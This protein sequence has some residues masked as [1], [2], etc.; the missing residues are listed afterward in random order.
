[1]KTRRRNDTY[2][3]KRQMEENGKKKY[4]D[5]KI[6]GPSKDEEQDDAME[7]GDISILN[8]LVGHGSPRSL[9]L[10]GTLRSG[11]V[12]ILI[13]NGCTLTFVQPGVV[14]RM[15]LSITES[16][17]LDQGEV[18]EGFQHE[19]GLLLFRGYRGSK[20]KTEDEIQRRIWDPGINT[21]FLDN[22][23]RTRK[24]RKQNYKTPS[25]STPSPSMLPPSASPPPPSP[26]P[27]P[28]PPPSPSIN[29]SNPNYHL[30]YICHI[31]HTSHSNQTMKKMKLKNKKSRK[32]TGWKA[33][34]ECA[35]F[36]VRVDSQ[37]HIDFT[38]TSSFK[39]GQSGRV[40]RKNHED[41]LLKQ[42]AIAN[43][44]VGGGVVVVLAKR[45]KEE[46]DMDI[47][48]ARIQL[49]GN[50][51]YAKVNTYRPKNVSKGERAE[52]V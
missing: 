45:D 52:I 34:C 35:I 12:R 41:S 6:T 4:E 11:R 43:K 29:Y 37:K 47:C 39:G 50:Q 33:G 27:S 21:L 18:L 3:E 28:P 42:L 32:K 1:M 49:H 46:M 23:L 40:K 22:T 9:Q 24:P 30:S 8:S 19:Q 48:K 36:M 38:L 14:K 16:T 7:S 2:V 15:H 17:R 25:A 51:I 10:W 20:K 44:S 31:R 13:D 26:P 5:I